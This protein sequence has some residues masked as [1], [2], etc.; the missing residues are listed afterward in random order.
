MGPPDEDIVEPHAKRAKADEENETEPGPEP[1]TGACPPKDDASST[2]LPLVAAS[3]RSRLRCKTTPAGPWVGAVAPA[4][5]PLV[6]SQPPVI[7]GTLPLDVKARDWWDSKSERDKYTYVWN[8]MKR[9]NVYNTYL[10]AQSAWIKRSRPATWGQLEPG[11]RAE[12]VKWVL[13]MARPQW[14]ACVGEWLQA[15]WGPGGQHPQAGPKREMISPGAQIV[16]TWQGPWGVVKRASVPGDIDELSATVLLKKDRYVQSVWE[17]ARPL[18]ERVQK[19]LEGHE[20]GA[21]LELCTRTLRESGVVRIHL[22]ACFISTQGNLKQTELS[23]LQIF[24]GVPHTAAQAARV[25]RRRALQYSGLYYVIAPKIGSLFTFSTMRPHHEFEVNAEW[26]WSMVALHKIELS[27][28]REEMVSAGKNVC[29]HLQ[30]LDVLEKEREKLAV[31]RL[32]SQR[33]KEIAKTRKAFKAIPSVDKWVRDLA[34]PVDRR[35]FLMLQGP[36][37]LGKTAYAFSLVDQGAALEVNCAG[38]E[39]PPLRAFSRA[40]HRLIL[41]DEASTG[42]VLKNRRLFQGPNTPVCVGSSPH[43]QRRVR[44]VCGRDSSGRGVEQLGG[45]ARSPPRIAARVARGQHGLRNSEGEALPGWLNF[46]LSERGGGSRHCHASAC[47]TG[48]VH[49]RSA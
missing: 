7:P 43:E 9:H 29:R 27:A 12:F 39:Y 8:H 38:V 14:P 2:S 21:S 34:V 17:K 19:M 33:A 20:W 40:K 24:G 10:Q 15:V 44:S 1:G 42:M 16:L 31:A 18:V 37:Q 23:A 49:T 28:A 47:M 46:S 25:H 3:G 6:S 45:G 48:G 11:H 22:H 35:K 13:C 5:A 30:N 32:I 36:S 26:I 41:F 4:A